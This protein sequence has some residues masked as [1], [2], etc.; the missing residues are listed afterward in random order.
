MGGVEG[1]GGKRGD[2]QFSVILFVIFDGRGFSPFPRS[3]A[4]RVLSARSAPG[5]GV[6]TSRLF[7]CFDRGFSSVL[8][9]TRALPSPF[10]SFQPPRED[11]RFVFFFPFRRRALRLKN[12]SRA[13]LAPSLFSFPPP[14]RPR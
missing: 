1:G 12:R 14:L 10:P 2:F 13:S 8:L 9:P 3:L 11:S 6:E 4:F 5:E 7:S